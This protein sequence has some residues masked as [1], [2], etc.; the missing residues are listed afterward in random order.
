M[1]KAKCKHCGES[2]SE[3]GEGKW[4]HPGFVEGIGCSNA[5]PEEK[6]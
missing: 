4:W 1:K 5:E 6:I 3:Y 2:C